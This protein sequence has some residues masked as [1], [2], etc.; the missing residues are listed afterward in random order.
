MSKHTPGPWHWIGDS[1][2]HRQYNIYA[3]GSAP[4]EHVCTVNNLSVEKLY[5]RDADVA[6][7]NARLIA[8][9]PDLL[10]ALRDFSDYVRNEQNSTD[11]AVIY[12]NTQIHR[13]VF[14]ARA[15][16]A[17]TTGEQA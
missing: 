12:S 3:P 9:A 6:L 10:D 13:L 16:I 2:T 1:L 4:Q 8:A 14:K 15:A 17:K 7:A 5:G 11:G